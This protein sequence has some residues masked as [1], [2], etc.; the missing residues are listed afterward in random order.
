MLLDGNR[1]CSEVLNKFC[2]SNLELQVLAI[3]NPTLKSLPRALSEI[4]ELNMLVLRGCD[5]LVNVDLIQELS[6]LTVLEISGACSL[7]KLPHNL[8]DKMTRL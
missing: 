5:F 8:F 7:E 4:K 2:Q 3:F 6:N 1:L